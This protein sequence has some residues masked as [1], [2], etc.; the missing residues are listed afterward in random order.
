MRRDYVAP[1]ERGWQ[2][3]WAEHAKPVEMG[4]LFHEAWL[5]LPERGREQ[6]K[7]FMRSAFAAGG[8]HGIGFAM[9]AETDSSEVTVSTV[10]ELDALPLC[11]ILARDSV[12]LRADLVVAGGR[13]WETR[14]GVLNSAEVLSIIGPL[15]VLYR[16][17]TEEE[18]R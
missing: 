15:R 3:F 4:D 9:D 11:T 16:P 5:N 1:L 18:N 2:E 10:E 8:L 7:L 12:P 14:H 13:G 6:M 17:V